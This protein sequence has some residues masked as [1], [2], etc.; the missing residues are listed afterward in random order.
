MSHSLHLLI[1]GNDIHLR[2][3]DEASEEELLSTCSVAM[4]DH[5]VVDFP[6][7]LAPGSVR[8]ST[9]VIHFEHVAGVWIDRD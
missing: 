9:V 5:R 4:R 6:N 1:S 7:T 3:P 8:R 2:M